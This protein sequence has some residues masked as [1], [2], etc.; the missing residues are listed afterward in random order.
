[1]INLL[2]YKEKRSIERIRNIRIAQ[3]V[4]SGTIILIIVCAVLL[5]PTL[6]TINSRFAIATTQMTALERDG[7]MA[8][9]IDLTTLQTRAQTVKEKLAVETG[10][11]PTARIESIRAVAK[12]GITI[13]RL[14]TEDGM[15]IE[16]F[17]VAQSREALQAFTTAINALP[18]IAMV[19]SPVSNFIKNKNGMFR[20][21]V[22]FK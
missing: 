9:D 1:M 12:S 22:S 20:V 6:I 3:T 21:V 4:I 19:D 17:G 14:T 8:S 15:I 10:I 11:S 16:V 5:V 7:M 18:N 2:P 13:N